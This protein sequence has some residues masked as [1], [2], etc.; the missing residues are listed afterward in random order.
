MPNIFWKYQKGIEK[1]QVVQKNL[2][3]IE[4]NLIT[5]ESFDESRLDIKRSLAEEN[6]KKWILHFKYVDQIK[7]PP[8]GKHI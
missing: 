2:E 4:I 3:N 7:L 5:D 6:T 8:S 1:Y